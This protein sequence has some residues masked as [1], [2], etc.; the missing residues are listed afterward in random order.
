VKGSNELPPQRKERGRA[1]Q[2]NCAKTVLLAAIYDTTGARG[3]LRAQVEIPLIILADCKNEWLSGPTVSSV[4][5]SIGR[6]PRTTRHHAGLLSALNLKARLKGHLRALSS[7]ASRTLTWG[8]LGDLGVGRRVESRRSHLGREKREMALPN[9]PKITG[10][11]LIV[12][13]T[14]GIVRA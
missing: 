4:V 5:H 1:L 14:N 10:G 6:R 2:R 13:K 9:P 3:R 11:E 8:R 7:A 12:H